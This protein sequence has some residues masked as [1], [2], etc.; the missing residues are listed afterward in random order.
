MN[1]APSPILQRSLAASAIRGSNG[2]GGKLSRPIGS[3]A[4]TPPMG[5]TLSGPG[6]N[7]RR[8][9]RAAYSSGPT[10]KGGKYSTSVKVPTPESLSSSQGSLSPFGSIDPKELA[11]KAVDLSWTLVRAVI[12]FLVRLPYNVFFYATHPK[13][14]KEKVTEIRELAKK[15]FDHY[16]TG[17]KVSMLRFYLPF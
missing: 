2:I 16:W 14:R 12:T 15:E 13:E 10:N 5:A 11:K 9:L 8:E 7:F 6:G 3:T 4:V 1:D 17:T